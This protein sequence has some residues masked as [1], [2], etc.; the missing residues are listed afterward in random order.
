M[1]NSPI[2]PVRRVRGIGER[3]A[4]EV[5]EGRFA[6]REP[7]SK[8]YVGRDKDERRGQNEGNDSQPPRA[9]A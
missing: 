5:V 1:G 8:G 7:D 3:Q 2:Q 9:W 6:E 4:R